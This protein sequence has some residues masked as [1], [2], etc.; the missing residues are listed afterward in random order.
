MSPAL[1]FAWIAFALSAIPFLLFFRNLR[2]YAP[3]S[4]ADPGRRPSLSVLIPARNEEA[5]IGAALDA[6]L[7]SHGVDL[8]VVVLDDAS[9]DDTAA[10][11]ASHAV[12]DPRVRLERAPPLP[13][14]WCGKQHACAVLARHARHDVLVFVDA[15]VRLSPDALARIAG[16]LHA[17]GVGLVSGFPRQ[18]TVTFLERLLLPFMHILLLGFLPIDFMRRSLSP[19]FGAG[20]GQLFAARR[21]AYEAAGGHG[22]IRESLHDGVRLPRAF[23]AAGFATDLFDATDLATCRMY[24]SA[25]EVWKGLGKNATE[26]LASPGAIVPWTLLLGGGQVLPWGVLVAT[27]GSGAAATVAGCALA[28]SYLVRLAAARRFRHAWEG[29]LLHPVGVLLLLAIQWQALVRK[30]AGRSPSWKGRSYPAAPA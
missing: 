16:F 1:L 8:E 22:A 7:R 27:G 19:A 24:R 17:T 23:R 2:S 10:I 9:D 3:P 26:G 12:R 20:C 30:V 25:G 13:D 14:G 21:D 4:A 18:E 28:F 6:V 5:S 11:V 15:D 29:A